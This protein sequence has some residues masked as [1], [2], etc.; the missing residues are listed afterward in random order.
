[1]I[2]YILSIVCGAALLA[3]DQLTKYYISSNF[4]LG[5][6]SDFIPGLIDITYIHNTG[7]AWG[8]LSGKTWVLLVIT[9]AVM[10]GCIVFLVKNK[11][12]SR[13]LVFAMSLILSGGMGNM[14]DRVFRNG[15]VIDFLHFEFWPTFPVFNVADCAIVVGAG[16]LILYF[17]LD[18]IKEYNDKKNVE[19]KEETNG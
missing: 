6:V 15:K 9:V 7:A 10:I 8:M 17:L 11:I 12:K 18:S 14:V 4:D 2:L 13:L 1:M 5:Y 16:L 3:V 19:N